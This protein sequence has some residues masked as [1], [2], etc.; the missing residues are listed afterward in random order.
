MCHL[1]AHRAERSQRAF[2]RSIESTKRQREEDEKS[3]KRQREEDEKQRL[4]ELERATHPL[5]PH[6][7]YAGLAAKY[8]DLLAKMQ[9]M[10]LKHTSDIKRLEDQRDGILVTY[11]W[12]MRQSDATCRSHTGLPKQGLKALFLMCS[13][14]GVENVLR[15]YKQVH[16]QNTHTH[17]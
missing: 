7:T 12:L 13:A 14:H 16:R 8:E 15:F 6:Y 1:E 5:V 2:D 3:A 17:T 10:E 11:D 4:E 9:E